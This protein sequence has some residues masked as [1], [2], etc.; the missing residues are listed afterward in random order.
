[1]I[2]G[3]VVS[4][5]RA[6]AAWAAVGVLLVLTLAAALLGL[7]RLV[8]RRVSINSLPPPAEASVVVQLPEPDGRAVPRWQFESPSSPPAPYWRLSTWSASDRVFAGDA[9]SDE[10]DERRELLEHDALAMLAAARYGRGAT[11]AGEVRHAG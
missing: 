4:S 3:D 7:A 5:V 2:R 1:M 10:D 11:P 9:D 8:V 6:A